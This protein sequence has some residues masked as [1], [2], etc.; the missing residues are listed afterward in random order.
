MQAH[1]RL[2]SP[3]KLL[4]L[5]ETAEEAPWCGWE[6]PWDGDQLQKWWQQDE[7]ILACGGGGEMMAMDG[8]DGKAQ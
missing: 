4:T 8:T 6:E 7:E 2:Y 1:L 5:Q 3:C